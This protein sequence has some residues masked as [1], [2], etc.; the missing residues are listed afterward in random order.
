MPLVVKKSGSASVSAG[1]HLLQAGRYEK[2]SAGTAEGEWGKRS[3]ASLS[4]VTSLD[5]QLIVCC[6]INELGLALV[7]EFIREQLFST[8]EGEK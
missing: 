3:L 4:Q 7:T 1:K 2:Q 5:S 8:Q 6:A